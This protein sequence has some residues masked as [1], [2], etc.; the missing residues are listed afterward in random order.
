MKNPIK[1]ESIHD[2]RKSVRKLL[3]NCLKKNHISHSEFHCALC[4]EQPV[5]FHH[6]NYDL[7]WFFIPLCRYHHSK[8]TMPR[9]KTKARLRLSH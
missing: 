2:K 8:Q 9:I 4:E 3:T 5:E 6:E 7:W 1:Y